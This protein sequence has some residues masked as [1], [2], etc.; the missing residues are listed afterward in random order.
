M[1]F[2]QKIGITPITKEIQLEFIDEDLMNGLWNIFKMDFLD[3]M[4]IGLLAQIDKIRYLS[5]TKTVISM[6]IQEFSRRG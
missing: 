6:K 2:S 1:R 5:I 4:T 3:N